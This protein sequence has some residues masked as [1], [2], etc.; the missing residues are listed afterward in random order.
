MNCNKTVLSC[1]RS[2]Q[3]C[4]QFQFVCSIKDFKILGIYSIVILGKL[5][6]VLK[7]PFRDDLLIGDNCGRYFMLLVGIQN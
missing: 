4:K 1:D 5:L 3:I 7:Y 6:H 2:G